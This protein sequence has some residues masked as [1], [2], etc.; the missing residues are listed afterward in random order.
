MSKGNEMSYHTIR[1][2]GRFAWAQYRKHE[3]N[4]MW[5]A[6][7]IYTRI[8]GNLWWFTPSDDALKETK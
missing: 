7:G 5:S 1:R 3:P 6:K 8:V 2:F 4:S